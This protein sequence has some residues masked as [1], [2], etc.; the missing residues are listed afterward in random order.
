[1]FC[2]N[3]GTWQRG[4][5]IFFCWVWYRRIVGRIVIHCNIIHAQLL[6]HAFFCL[7]N[8][9]A[10]PLKHSFPFLSS[11]FCQTSF[12][13][14]RATEKVSLWLEH[15][16]KHEDFWRF[17]CKFHHE[18]IGSKLS[19]RRL[20]RLSENLVEGVCGRSL[21]CEPRDAFHSTKNSEISGPKLKWTVKIPEKVFENLGIR[22]ECN[23]FDE[24]SGIIEIFVFHSQEMSGLVSLPKRSAIVWYGYPFVTVRRA[25]QMNCQL[26]STQCA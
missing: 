7:F 8:F 2:K 25:A 4:L 9:F 23:L 3:V 24:F 17:A 21:F 5:Q 13:K 1:M 16:S 19:K 15:Y 20:W 11:P 26:E 10:Q 6:R 12:K 14:N 22:F 18:S